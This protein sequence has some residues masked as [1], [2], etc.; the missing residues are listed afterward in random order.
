M[1]PLEKYQADLARPEFVR[2]PAQEEAVRALDHLYHRLLE[3]QPAADAGAPVARASAS[4]ARPVHVG[5]RG[6]RQNLPD[7]CVLRVPAVRG[8]RRMHFH[9]FMQKV[10]RQLRDRQGE[11]NR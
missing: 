5:R 6:A 1:T 2:D 4:P 8:K 9:R 11:K 3:D 10:H 7:G